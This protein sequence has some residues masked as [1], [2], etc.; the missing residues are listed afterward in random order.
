MGAGASSRFGELPE[1]LDEEASRKWAA[2][3]GLEEVKD[4]PEEKWSELRNA[5]KNI[6]TKAQFIQLFQD[7]TVQDE[8]AVG[9]GGGIKLRD[10][11]E[12]LAFDQGDEEVFTADGG[13]EVFAADGE[14][15]GSMDPDMDVGTFD[16]DP[17][18]ADRDE[19]LGGMM[20]PDL[21]VVGRPAT[22]GPG[23][24]GR[25][26]LLPPPQSINEPSS[27]GLEDNEEIL[28]VDGEAFE[29][30]VGPGCFDEKGLAVDAAKSPTQ[31]SSGG[32][33]LEGSPIKT[34]PGK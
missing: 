4:W 20:M 12:V 25:A 26:P 17:D 11:A 32:L 3:F 23:G 29:K 7:L 16:M 24:S 1:E 28:A 5:D 9:G 14:L 30:E 27:S 10:S 21:A 33:M 31:G 18:S 22:A 15:E 34:S 19:M 8:L 13:E 2:A 6:I